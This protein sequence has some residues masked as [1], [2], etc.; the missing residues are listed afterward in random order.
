MQNQRKRRRKPT[1]RLSPRKKSGSSSTSIFDL[2]PVVD[3]ICSHLQRWDYADASLIN[4]TFHY[5]CRRDLWKRLIFKGTHDNQA[6][7]KEHQRTLL[8]NSQWIRNLTVSKIHA[9]LTCLADP[10]SQCRNLESISCDLEHET[11]KYTSSL[12]KLLALNPKIINLTFKALDDDPQNYDM[13]GPRNIDGITQVVTALPHLTTLQYLSVET[14]GRFGCMDLALFLTNLPPSVEMFSLTELQ[15]E[16]SGI[17]EPFSL[18]E[19]QEL[20]WPNVYPNIVYLSFGDFDQYNLTSLIVP[21]L[22]RCPLLENL[23]LPTMH[24]FD[25]QFIA[26][27]LR[28]SCPNLRCL[29]IYGSVEEESLLLIVDAIPALS[30]LSLLINVSTTA[31]FVPQLVAKWFNSLTSVSFGARTMVQSSDI[32]LLLTSCPLLEDF[33]ICSYAAKKRPWFDDFHY[34]LLNLSDLAQSEWT[35]QRLEVLDIVFHDERVEQ[36]TLE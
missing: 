35:C 25:L 18:S 2:P 5:A 3:T 26:E 30:I 17:D 22:E 21:L 29:T 33:C 28:D 13:V 7:S 4:K 36:D 34:S 23:I 12:V 27:A 19:E 10:S 11:S 16:D 14:A 20:C 24:G 31:A 9:P 6:I 32:Q 15:L 1:R 8:A